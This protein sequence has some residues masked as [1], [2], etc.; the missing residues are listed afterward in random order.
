M[1]LHGIALFHAGTGLSVESL[2]F[3]FESVCC[4]RTSATFLLGFETILEALI[5]LLEGSQLIICPEQL[6]DHVEVLTEL[7]CM[8]MTKKPLLYR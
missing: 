7:H 4:F 5:D 6:T 3:A 1:E 8:Y 2:T